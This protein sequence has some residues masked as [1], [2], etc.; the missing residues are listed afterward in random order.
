MTAEPD[1]LPLP[2]VLALLDKASPGPWRWSM[3]GN[4]VPDLYSD[5]CEIAAVYSEHM[6]DIGVPANAEAIIAAVNYL[7]AH[8]AKL[9][10]LQREIEALRAEVADR[11]RRHA[12]TGRDACQLAS[13]LNASAKRAETVL[14]EA[15]EWRDKFA[16][17]KAR[18]ER[19][20]EA[21][22][23][24][25][26]ACFAEFCGPGTEAMEPDYSK[27][28]FPE[29][30]CNIPFVMIRRARATLAQENNDA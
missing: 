11:S 24:L 14:A 25:A 9:A 28:R 23:E 17:E 6:D 8:G 30:R 15:F 19:L 4:I 18:A 13:R 12:A 20:A 22:R 26:D 27:L 5:D 7:R 29:D 1:L 16:A 21:L 3:N 10:E 2:E